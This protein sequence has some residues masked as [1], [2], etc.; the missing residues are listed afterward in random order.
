MLSFIFSSIYAVIIPSI[1]PS[2]H[3]SNHPSIQ[4]LLLL[5]SH[6]FP[7]SRPYLDGDTKAAGERTDPSPLQQM[8]EEHGH[9]RQ[10]RQE[11]GHQGE[12]TWC[13]QRRRNLRRSLS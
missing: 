1:H 8:V 7:L 13:R 4:P 6:R 9:L 5:T 12:L 2:I 10:R 11:E 3:P